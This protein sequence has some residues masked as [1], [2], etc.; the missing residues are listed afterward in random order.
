MQIEISTDELRELM[1]ANDKQIRELTNL[2]FEIEEL[3]E[4][5]KA[6]ETAYSS[7]IA[8]LQEKLGPL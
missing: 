8:R 5:V 2:T 6:N 4:R 1:L 3:A 7:V